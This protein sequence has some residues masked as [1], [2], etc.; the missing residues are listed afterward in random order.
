KNFCKLVF[1]VRLIHQRQIT[2]DQLR[3]AHSAIIEFTEE[4]ELLYYQ[5]NPDRIH[6]CRQ[7]VH[8]LAHLA[9]E[10]TLKGPPIY[11]T[12]WAMERT[13][14]NLG[15]EI[16]QHSNPYANLSQRGLRRSQVNALKAMCPD[17]DTNSDSHLPRGARDL[18][19]GYTLLRA[20]DIAERPVYGDE[21]AAIREYLRGDMDDFTLSITRWARLGLPNG[22]IARSA[23]KEKLKALKDV[24]MARNIKLLRNGK[25][26]FAEVQYYFRAKV[27]NPAVDTELEDSETSTL[28]LV[29]IYSPPDAA[30]LES[31]Y[32]TVW[33]CRYQGNASLTVVDVKNITSVVAMVPAGDRENEYFVVEKPGLEVAYM[34]GIEEIVM[35]E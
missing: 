16:K 32:N 29:S 30:I 22:Q 12:Q 34:G 3:A 5:R 6:F 11:Y 14:G 28:A 1:A 19:D 33:I 10:T 25:I 8:A 24:R 26:D 2:T 13:I 15:E 23:W 35:E 18:G 21:G 27:D 17:L 20:R 7:S 31:S 9:P 4:F